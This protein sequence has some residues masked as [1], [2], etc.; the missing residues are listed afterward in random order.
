MKVPVGRISGSVLRALAY[1]TRSGP[2]K[3]ALAA[4]VRQELGIDRVRR[5]ARDARGYLPYDLLPQRARE[6]H[7]RPSDQLPETRAKG[8]PRTARDLTDAYRSG[9]TT[10]EDVVRRSLDQARRLANQSV[11]YDVYTARTDDRAAVEARAS[12]ARWAAGTPLSELDG[13]PFAVKEEMDV[14]G[15]PTRL[16]TGFMPHVPAARDATLVSRLRR[17]GAIVVGQ[18]P[19]TEYGLSPLGGNAHRNMPRNAHDPG[20][21][22]GGSSTGSAV[23]VALGLVPFALGADGGGSIRVPASYNGVYGLKP[24][25]GRISCAG[26]G[27]PGGTSVVH[28]GPI[29]SSTRDLALAVE[30][31]AGPDPADRATLPQPPLDPGELTSA[32]ARGV[33]GLRLGVPESEW[34]DA[35]DEIGRVGRQALAG[36]EKAG[37]VLIPVELPLSRH[38]AAIGYLTIAVEARAALRAVEDE[39]WGEL[40]LDLRIFLAGVDAFA[41][42]DYVDA[43]RLREKLRGE[44]ASALREVDAIALPSTKS[45]APSVTD[46]EAQSGFIDTRALDGACRFAFLGNLTG[47]PAGTAPVGRSA[48]GL[49]IGLQ[50]LGDAWDEA[51]VLAVLAELERQGIAEVVRPKLAVDLLG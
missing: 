28:F 50:I 33:V 15:I 5:L 43:Q 51:C 29:A 37:A 27:S 31:A 42:D 19:M 26:H 8:W 48:A 1:G 21:L 2:L 14:E 40:G 36:L 12:A 7:A 35:D 32:L 20:R 45:V 49:P 9:K 18:T 13:V 30:L 3:L 41:S 22:A 23:A 24:T 16:G 17:A 44:L 46:A 38:A 34:A 10:P 47:A 39:H 25:Y 4:V 11:Y 6:N